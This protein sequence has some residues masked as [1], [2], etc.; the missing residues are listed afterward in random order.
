MILS[1]GCISW[2]RPRGIWGGRKNLVFLL[3]LL[4]DERTIRVILRGMGRLLIGIV[5]GP[6]SSSTKTQR[7]LK[8]RIV[9]PSLLTTSITSSANSLDFSTGFSLKAQFSQNEYS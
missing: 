4:P 2:A 9:T 5:D 6:D 7:L 8:Q 3:V 1:S